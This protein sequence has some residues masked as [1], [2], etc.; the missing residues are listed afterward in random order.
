M[1]D[2]FRN[3]FGAEWAEVLDIADKSFL[4]N[5]VNNAYFAV[6]NLL[7]LANMTL[8]QLLE[9]KGMSQPPNIIVS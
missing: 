3:Y 4:Y 9:K 1:H 6:H 2:A 5:A 7:P 8:E